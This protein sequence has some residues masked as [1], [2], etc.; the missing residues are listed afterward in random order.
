MAYNRGKLKRE[1]QRGE[2][3]VKC[4]GVYTD[5][6]AFDAAMGYQIGKEFVPAIYFPDFWLWLE[7]TGLKNTYKGAIGMTDEDRHAD[8]EITWQYD[9]EKQLACQG[10]ICFDQEEFRGFGTC[11]TDEH[12]DVS[13]SFGYRSYTFKRKTEVSL[14]QAIQDG[15]TEKIEEINARADRGEIV[16]IS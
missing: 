14:L 10:G 12:G 1:I 13:L 8:R 6:Y 2:W 3:L 5:D 4:D 11:W 9:K 15:D 16:R 7:E